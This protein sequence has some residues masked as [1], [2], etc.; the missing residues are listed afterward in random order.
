MTT[1]EALTKAIQIKKEF[2]AL[3]TQY[4]LE[5]K[6]N[7]DMWFYSGYQISTNGENNKK[8][9]LEGDGDTYCLEYGRIAYED[10]QYVVFFAQDCF[11]D[12]G[13]HLFLQENRVYEETD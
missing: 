9:L 6:L 3:N 10:E 5:F 1:N 7:E 2:S 13:Y 11:G 8:D 4:G 12:S